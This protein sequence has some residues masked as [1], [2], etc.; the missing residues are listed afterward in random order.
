MLEGNLGNFVRQIS[1]EK[2]LD[3]EVVKSAIE[4][5]ILSASKKG[6]MR[7]KN[8]RP[9]FDIETGKL[10]IFVEKNVVEEV[11]DSKTEIKLKA[12]K[13]INH[14]A[15]MGDVVEVE[16]DPIEFGRI[17][18]QSVR[19]GI[20]QRLRDAEHDRI[21]NEYI[22]KVGMVVTGIVQRFERKNVIVNL[23][24]V[25]TILPQ[26][27]V[28]FGTHYRY[29]D[30]IKVYIQDVQRTQRGP[31]IRVSR[32]C[33]ELVLKLFE[34]EV[35]E[36]ADGTV[37]IMGIAR[38]SGVRTKIA[39]SSNNPD[40]DP[41]GACVGMKG[42]RVQMIVRELENE[43]ID[44]IPF[45]N[46]PRELIKAAL[47]PAEVL[48]IILNEEARTAQIIVSQNSLSLAIGKRGQNA[49]LAAKLTGWKI[50]ILSEERRDLLEKMEELNR[51]YLEDFLSQVEG[52]SQLAKDALMKS[53]YNT[54]EKISKTAPS[55]LLNFTNGDIQTAETL[56]SGAK[57]YLDALEELAK[58]FSEKEEQNDE[59][60]NSREED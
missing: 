4:Q 59:K 48:N 45:S 56:V 25:E 27:E 3:V 52:L 43:K 6:S 35:P 54:V 8:T 55:L 12:A 42:S 57:E 23:G 44:V 5:A 21:Y 19:Q 24:K 58:E 10:R 9:D 49:K 16:I 33:P 14:D 34:Q 37:K 1:K 38:E 47:N 18:A 41:V 39:V 36:I 15:E 22:G 60:P 11:M 2:D 53:P 51:R 50:D 29:G 40:V 20:L 13:K 46:D 32:A 31:E 28:P 17:A 26:S 7:L 30:R